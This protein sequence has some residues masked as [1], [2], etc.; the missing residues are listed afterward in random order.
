MKSNKRGKFILKRNFEVK[1]KFLRNF[2]LEDFI[3]FNEI[4]CGKFRE[5]KVKIVSES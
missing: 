1:G 3:Y 5:R 4:K 2:L